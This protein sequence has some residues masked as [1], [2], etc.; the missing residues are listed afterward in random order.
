MEIEYDTEKRG[1]LGHAPEIHKGGIALNGK[2]LTW[3]ERGRL[4]LR[5]GIRLAGTILVLLFLVYGAPPLLGLLMPFVLALVL[6][7]ILNPAIVKVQ[8]RFGGS[9]KALSL[10]LLILI[11][12]IAGGVLAALVY[13]IVSEVASLV[14]NWPSIWAD[15]LQPAIVGMEDFLSGLFAGL[16]DQVSQTTTAALDKLVA[17]LNEM[18]PSMLSHVGSAAGSFA[19]SIPSFAVALVI[20]VMATYFIASDYPRLRLMVTD[21]LSPGVRDFFGSVKRTAVAAFGG[22]VKAQLILSVVIF[23]ILL[24]GFVVI[25]QPY[26]VLLAFLLAVL[27]FIPIVG[28]G[29]VMVPWAVADLFLGEYR[30]AVELMVIWGIIALFRRGAEP[31]VVG[32]Q[33]GLSPILSLISIYVGMKIAGV[34]G[35]ILGPVL[36]MVVI[37]VGRLGVLDGVLSDLRMAARD[38]TAI[39][40]NRPALETEK[41]HKD[42]ERHN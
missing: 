21:R 5:L 26:S 10:V 2:E 6:T 23:F 38:L 25:N 20:F 29:T 27:D 30:H 39:L 37:N 34:A 7:W 19:F 32:D 15:S 17:W 9:R 22:Y 1:G 40:K 28:S 14:M 36:C 42:T 8:R 11:F 12:T 24:V 13:S 16:P 33:T 35:M 18:I 3:R 31:K 4:W 41:E